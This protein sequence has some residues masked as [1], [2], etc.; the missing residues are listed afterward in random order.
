[1]GARTSSAK[2]KSIPSALSAPRKKEYVF[3][4]TID[5]MRHGILAKLWESP[6]ATYWKNPV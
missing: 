4:S 1:M 5:P 3:G 6:K 2:L